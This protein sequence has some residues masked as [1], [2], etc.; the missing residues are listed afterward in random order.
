MKYFLLTLAL[1]TSLASFANQ[2]LTETNDDSKAFWLKAGGAAAAIAG[3]YVMWR[4]PQARAKV[5][6]T[7]LPFVIWVGPKAYCTIVGVYV[8][9]HCPFCP[10]GCDVIMT[11]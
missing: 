2:T 11:W 6:A 5:A 3:A 7:A 4:Y 10:P 1:C 9:G 8:M